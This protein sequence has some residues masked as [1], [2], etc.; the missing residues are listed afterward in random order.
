MTVDVGGEPFAFS[1]RFA[2]EG[3]A[4]PTLYRTTA[5]AATS[6]PA[7]NIGYT[8]APVPAGPE[9]PAFPPPVPQPASMAYGSNVPTQV[10]VNAD[11]PPEIA[12]KWHRYDTMLIGESGISKAQARQMADEEFG[13]IR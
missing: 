12:S 3:G 7:P 1:F 10:A 13:P 9:N 8:P 4:A 6:M 11:V 2:P 5:V